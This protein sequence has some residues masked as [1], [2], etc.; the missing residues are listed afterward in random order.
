MSEGRGRMKLGLIIDIHE[1]V[2]FLR[3]ALDRF[4]QEKVDQIVVIGDVFETDERIEGTCRLLADAEAVGVWLGR[5]IVVFLVFDY[6]QVV[7]SYAAPSVEKYV[8][9]DAKRPRCPCILLK[10][11]RLPA[12]DGDE[13][14]QVQVLMSK[15]LSRKSDG[16]MPCCRSKSQLNS[17]SSTRSPLPRNG[18]SQKERQP[19]A[20]DLASRWPSW[21]RPTC[22]ARRKRGATVLRPSGHRLARLRIGCG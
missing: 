1:Q 4:R 17:S 11:V 20:S 21:P 18:L 7:R 6:E 13:G 15:L 9:L 3:I 2:E 22:A 12:E 16:G 14:T 10:P 8:P 5:L 19:A